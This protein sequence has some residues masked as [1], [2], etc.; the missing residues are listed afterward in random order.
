MNGCGYHAH[1]TDKVSDAWFIH[2][3]LIAVAIVAIIQFL[4]WLAP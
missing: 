2:N 1:A 4:L 3:W